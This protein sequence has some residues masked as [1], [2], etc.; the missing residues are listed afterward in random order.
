MNHYLNQCPFQLF[1]LLLLGMG[2]FACQPASTHKKASTKVEERVLIQLGGEKQYVEITGA[3]NQNPVLL[4]IH[5]GPGWPQTP[6]L[7]YFSAD[8]SKSFILTTWDQR[9]SGLSFQNNSNPKNLSLQQIIQ[10]AH[11]LTLL[12]KQKFKQDKIYLVGYSWGSL[13]GML[14]AERFPE[15][16]HAYIGLAQVINLRSAVQTS[17]KW[18]A[19]QATANH[20]QVALNTLAQLNKPGFCQSEL[21]CF[22][23]QQEL[24]N[25]YH[26]AVYDTTVLAKLEKAMTQ[27]PDYQKYDWEK[28]FQFS[29]QHLE[30]DLFATNL[31]KVKELKVPVY[32]LLGRHDWNVPSV[33]AEAF[34]KKLK[35]PHKEIIWFENSAHE[36]LEEEAGKFNTT[37]VEKLLP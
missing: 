4:F 18:I 33:L 26:G 35:A 29:I 25:K 32:F 24:L 10:D 21:D 12:L 37:L 17:R 14:L 19:E 34:L 1:T 30:K 9:G 6:Q 23:Q 20:D 5:G 2:S 8:L 13:V 11:E 3:S 16:Y 7:R 15:D 27:Y 36:L 22:F 31:E 28:G